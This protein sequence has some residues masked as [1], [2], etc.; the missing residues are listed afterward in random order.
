MERM[1]GC[2]ICDPGQLELLM[3]LYLIIATQKIG[4]KRWEAML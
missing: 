3:F 2:V 4:E 1:D